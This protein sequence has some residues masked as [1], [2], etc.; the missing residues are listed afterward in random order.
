MTTS[1]SA[2]LGLSYFVSEIALAIFKRARSGTK[3]ASS[4]RVLWI[5]IAVSLYLGLRV[6]QQARSPSFPPA[7]IWVGVVLFVCGIFLRWWSIV[8]LGRFFTI[9]VAIAADHHLVDSGPYR[10]VRHPSYTGALVAFLG[11]GL[12]LASWPT[13]ALILVPIFFAFV[14]RMQ[15]EERALADA[16]G[17]SYHAYCR[18]T[19][20][21]VPFVY[22]KKFDGR[23]RA[24]QSS[25]LQGLTD[26]RQAFAENFWIAAE[27]DAE[28]LR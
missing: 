8:E 25:A 19:K 1:L 24:P 2:V 7:L 10:F 6:A 12:T 4:L 11:F 27:A 14:Y 18:R 22:W 16:L 3:E 28:V 15:V 17:E 20:R 21:L 26:S 9:D 13:L 23:E 5:V